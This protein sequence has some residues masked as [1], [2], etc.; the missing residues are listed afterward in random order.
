MSQENVEIVR[1]R[2]SLRGRSGQTRTVDQRLAVRFPWIVAVWQRLITRLSPASRL[3]QALMV[4]AMQS[5]FEAYNRGDLEVCVL[6]YHP[7]V[8]FRHPEDHALGFDVTYRGLKG[9]GEFAAYWASGWGEHRFEPRELIDLGD[10]FLVLSEVFARGAG[11]GVSLTQNHAMLATFDKYGKVV[12]Q[13]DFFDHAEALE[14]VGLS[15]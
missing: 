4:R 2:L 7:E 1:Q 13:Q 14:A 3:R 8:E 5:G 10:R 6:I 9:Y 12:R 15:E 11:S